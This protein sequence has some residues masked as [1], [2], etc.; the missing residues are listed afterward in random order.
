[1]KKSYFLWGC[2]EHL[3][4]R[5]KW[6]TLHPGYRVKWTFRRRI[7]ACSVARS[8]CSVFNFGSHFVYSSTLFFRRGKTSRHFRYYPCDETEHIAHGRTNSCVRSRSTTGAYSTRS[9]I[10]SHKSRYNTWSW[11]CA[12]MLWTNNC[13]RWW[14]DRIWRSNRSNINERTV[15]TRTPFETPPHV[16]MKK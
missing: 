14:N 13:T 1:M 9:I 12:W 4:L 15:F 11:L 7:A 2:S 16:T 10:T 3:Y 5:R 6:L 8:V